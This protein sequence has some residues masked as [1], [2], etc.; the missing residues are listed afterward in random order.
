MYSATTLAMSEALGQ[1]FKRAEA[2][3]GLVATLPYRYDPDARR[4]IGYFGPTNILSDGRFFYTMV[5]AT[6]YQEQKE[7]SCLLRTNDLSDPASWR[8][9][10]GNDF[11][12]AFENPYRSDGDP[13]QHVCTPVDPSHLT[14]MIMS[15]VRHAPSGQY[16]ALF[17]AASD[18]NTAAQDHAVYVAASP[19]LIHWSA[20]TKVIPITLPSQAKCNGPLPLAYPSLLDPQSPSR[21]FETVGDRPVLFMTCSTS[22]IVIPVSIAT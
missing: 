10:D 18:D 8:A 21:N 22:I 2:N 15:L 11:N 19:D 14:N 12:V 3:G 16:L 13:A 20:K 17:V 1:S 7:G 9:W 4:H 6:A 5:Y